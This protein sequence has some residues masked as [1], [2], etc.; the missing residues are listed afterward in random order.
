MIT[1]TQ[2]TPADYADYRRF[3]ENQ[4]FELCTYTLSSIIAWSN[5]EYTPYGAEYDGAFLVSAEFAEVKENRHLLLPV[6]PTKIYSPEEL[7]EVAE[8]A[9]HTEFWFVPQDYVTYFGEA[10]VGRYFTIEHQPAFDD[11]V[12][13]VEDLAGLKGNRY[14]KK[15]NL[16]KQFQR[17]YVEPGKVAI[18]PIHRDNVEDCLLFLEEWCRERGCDDGDQVD[19]ACEK[20]AAI[21]SLVHFDAFG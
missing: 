2:L 19:L 7:V 18:D 13:R 16:I 8:L 5:S 14:S 6:S 17:K 15:R 20:Q 21:N 9:G 4:R 10:V 12:Y 1:F 3:F 11:Y